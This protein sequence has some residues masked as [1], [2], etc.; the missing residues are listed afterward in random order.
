MPSKKKIFRELA[1]RIE[2]A[3]AEL[4][5]RSKIDPRYFTP[6]IDLDEL[7]GIVYYL[8]GGDLTKREAILE[9][10]R[11]TAYNYLYLNK[12]KQLNEIIK[13]IAEIKRK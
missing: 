11:E 4:K 8:S 3:S 1:E 12:V 5:S 6:E 9:M 13:N 7:E 2:S 10:D